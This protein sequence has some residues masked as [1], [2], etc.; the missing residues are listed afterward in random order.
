MENTDSSSRSEGPV[1]SEYQLDVALTQKKKISK[2]PM[3]TLFGRRISKEHHNT[4]KK[5]YPLFS[6]YSHD[7]LFIIT[8]IR[9]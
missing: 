6:S 1:E 9:R 7:M 4:F 2:S 5:I 3:V 8:L